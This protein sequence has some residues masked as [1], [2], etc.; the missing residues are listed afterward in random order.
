MLWHL[1]KGS[2]HTTIISGS[3]LSKLHL[4]WL[5]KINLLLFS[6]WLH[7]YSIQI[8]QCSPSTIAT[9]HAVS[10]KLL[11]I[12]LDFFYLLFYDM[13]AFSALNT[14]RSALQTLLLDPYLLFSKNLTPDTVQVLGSKFHLATINVWHLSCL[15]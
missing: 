8:M 2:K 7:Q 11:T 4:F 14:L 15:F 1:W 12:S 9:P 13:P 3:N 10:S 5:A 6:T